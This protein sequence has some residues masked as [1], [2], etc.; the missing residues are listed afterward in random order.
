MP[1]IS[2]YKNIKP[3]ITQDDSE[4]REL[5][6]PAVQGNRLQ[7]LAEAIVK[8][9]EITRLHFHKK[10]EELY[11][12]L[13]G[14]GEMQLEDKVFRVNMGDTICIPP[15]TKHCIENTGEND[16]KILCCCSPA[17]THADTI[18]T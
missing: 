12:I 7:S 6:H 2:H 10:S 3:Y 15:G 9:G 16:L 17:Y 1:I 4:I 18:T 11:F 8:P 13:Q 5:M 14:T